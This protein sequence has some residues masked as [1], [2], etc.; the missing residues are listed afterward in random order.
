MSVLVTIGRRQITRRA[1]DNQASMTPK[2]MRIRV[3]L[4][5]DVPRGAQYPRSYLK[6]VARNAIFHCAGRAQF[7]SAF[8]AR[9]QITEEQTLRTRD[10]AKLI[11]PIVVRANAPL[12]LGVP[13][14]APFGKLSYASRT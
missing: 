13:R 14:F 8:Y 9:M 5:S 10:F 2:T 12:L 3:A 7:P 11:L 1:G 4:F 6:Y